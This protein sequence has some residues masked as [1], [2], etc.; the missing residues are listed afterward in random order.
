[1]K[2]KS[3]FPVTPAPVLLAALLWILLAAS[4]FPQTYLFAGSYTGGLP[5]NGIRVFKFDPEEITL[6]P[7]SEVKGVVN[8]SFL[9]LSPDGKT[10]YACT[11]TRTPNAGSI[12]AFGF[13]PRKGRLKLLNK[14]PS[15]GENPVYISVNQAQTLLVCA[16][17]AASTVAAFRLNHNGSLAHVLQVLR[18]EGSSVDPIRQTASHAHAAVF[19]PDEAYLLV[20]DLGADMIRVLAVDAGSWQPLARVESLDVH[21]DPGSGP[22]HLRFHPNGKYV[23]CVEE[24][25]GTLSVY[26]YSDGHLRALQRHF[27]YQTEMDV[28]S[29]ADIHVS[30]DGR[31]VYVSN[32]GTDENS[33]AIFA[34]GQEGA[35]LTL[36]GHASSE[37]ET[38]RSFCLAPDNQ[39]LLAANQISGNIAVMVRDSAT[40]KLY[41]D[42]REYLMPQVSSLQMR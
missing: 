8:P 41:F 10:L 3:A 30:G 38:P 13:N 33:I 11:E 29:G 22:R 20:P 27:T 19:S 1:M 4:A 12:S 21:T 17:Y 42:G 5:S 26:A 7:K 23:Y 2:H 18:F 28:Y 16:N 9:S 35:V 32:R 25:S 6:T 39:S 37:G 31:F 14:L 36:V 40:G 15:H 24:L 34:V